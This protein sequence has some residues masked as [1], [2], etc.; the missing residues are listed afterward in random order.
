MRPLLICYHY[1]MERIIFLDIDGV[2]ITR[3]S[4]SKFKSARKA[5][6]KCVRQLNR[7]IAI[8][9]RWGSRPSIVMSST[10]RIKR[11]IPELIT[12]LETFGVINPN[13]VD[14]TPNIWGERGHE[15]L[16]WLDVNKFKGQFVILDDETSDMGQMTPFVVKTSMI[17]G[18][19]GHHVLAVINH[20]K[21]FDEILY[22]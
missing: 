16:T 1:T 4:I 9:T 22:G 6:P 10:W 14:K 17:G 21:Y 20:F 7:L 5:D 19:Q 13:V 3:Q 8:M 2:L 12:L 18:L 15:I 11:T